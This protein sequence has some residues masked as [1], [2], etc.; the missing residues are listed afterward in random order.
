MSKFSFIILLIP[1]TV[2]SQFYTEKDILGSWKINKCE[3]FVN[4]VL[5]KTSYLSE[6]PG[7]DNKVLEGRNIG[8]Y[9]KKVNTIMKNITGAD[10]YFNSDSTVSWDATIDEINFSSAFWH[11]AYSG[12]CIICCLKNDSPK[13][14]DMMVF[15]IITIQPNMFY[16]KTFVLGIELRI[17]MIKL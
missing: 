6:K 17:A 2:F 7:P 10:I 16:L 15:R 1:V 9:D 3:I 12:Q 11:L 14:S 5:Y 8:T 13:K 4:N